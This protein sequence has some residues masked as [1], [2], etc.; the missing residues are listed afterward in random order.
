[1]ITPDAFGGGGVNHGGDATLR[2]AGRTA[3]DEGGWWAYDT[4][5]SNKMTLGRSVERKEMS[6]LAPFPR[7]G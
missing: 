5:Q 6:G 7:E 1:M 3:A 4:D 2:T